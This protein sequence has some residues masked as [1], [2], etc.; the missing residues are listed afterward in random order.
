M[1]NRSRCAAFTL[2]DRPEI[3]AM[4]GYA[5]GSA[6]GIETDKP[7]L[8]LVGS[9][10]GGAGRLE[11]AYDGLSP[12]KRFVSIDVAGHNSFTDQC[13]IIHG[14][15]NFLDD[16]VASGFPIPSNLLDL[17]IDGCLPRNLAPDRFWAVSSHFTIAH[18]RDALGMDAAGLGDE[19]ATAFDGVTL[20]YRQ[21]P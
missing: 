15:N 1:A 4:I 20:R 2:P 13:A 14:G 3:K 5:T 19:V 6:R 12:V 16:L 7:I 11:E 9:E 10:D 18:I 17:A 21:A 8:L